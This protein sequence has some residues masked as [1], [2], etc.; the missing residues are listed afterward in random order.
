[1]EI[2]HLRLQELRH[3]H[4]SLADRLRNVILVVN[5]D[6]EVVTALRAH[7]KRLARRYRTSAR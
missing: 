3:A 5:A 1:L 2:G 6:G 7:S 4:G